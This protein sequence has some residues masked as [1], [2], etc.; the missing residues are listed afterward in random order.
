MR[1]VIVAVGS[2]GDVA[3]Y[4]GLAVAL[5]AAGHPTAIATHAPYERAVRD[6]GLEFR[7]LPMD[8]RQVLAGEH[9]R[10]AS[11][12]GPLAMRHSIA[13][14][15][16]HQRDLGQGILAAAEGAEHLL[17]SPMAWLGWHVAQGL[18]IA[19]SG[20]YLQPWTPTAEFPPAAMTTRSLGGWGNKAA[21][22]ALRT[23][24]QRP[25]RGVIDDLR[26]QLGLAPMSP[27]RSFA[28]MDADSWPVLYGFSPSVVPPP[29]DWP[30]WHRVVG[31]WWPVDDPAW[32]PS[33]EL[34]DFLD[35]G[36][37]PV[38]LGFGSMPADD[39]E[40]LG[41]LLTE[42]ARTARVRA[43]VQTG[44]ADLQVEGDDVLAVGHVP[45]SWLFPRAAA[46]VH[47][48]GAG[49]TAAGLRAGVPTVPVPVMV[50]QPFWAK[51]L[52][53]LGVA[54]EPLPFTDLTSA[55][56]A[57]RITAAVADLSMRS[58]ATDLAASLRHEDGYAP[59][60]AALESGG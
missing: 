3:P 45:H 12:A 49:T 18:G 15:A 11:G 33:D 42:A 37:A 40:R 55:G 17:L 44:D 53:G 20:A 48:C 59:V 35:A 8:P 4:T 52:R 30:D 21:A 27:G 1:V 34:R 36:P 23:A 57:S 26:A 7:P 28:Q 24:G 6:A 32:T 9:G 13:M 60:V 2:Y 14:I 50:D 41:R 25:A 16:E 46:V 56:L 38:V 54:T 22:R 10:A 47:H 43:V 19:S 29:R 39:P 51:R 5:S 31:Y 58:R